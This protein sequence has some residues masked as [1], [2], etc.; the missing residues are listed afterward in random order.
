MLF[1]RNPLHTSDPLRC[2]EPP[3]GGAN[4]ILAEGRTREG[5][6]DKST[7][8]NDD[9]VRVPKDG[10]TTNCKQGNLDTRKTTTTKGHR[11]FLGVFLHFFTLP[12]LFR[13]VT[14]HALQSLMLGRNKPVG[15]CLPCD[16]SFSSFGR[17]N[18]RNN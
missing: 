8:D 15:I 16:A 3:R 1:P 4:P 9:D 7:G 17:T 5:G 2:G 13:G 6:G 11:V 12:E 18:W 14:S 10:I